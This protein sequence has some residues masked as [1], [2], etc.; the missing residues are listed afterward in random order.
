MDKLLKELKKKEKVLIIIKKNGLNFGLVQSLILPYYFKIKEK[1]VAQKYAVHRKTIERYYKSL[2][3]L[4]E[5]DFERLIFWFY[6]SLKKEVRNSS[7]A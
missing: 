1:D 4:K 3:S 5:S 6:P 2:G 7:Q